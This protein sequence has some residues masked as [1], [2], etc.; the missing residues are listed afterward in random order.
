MYTSPKYR[1]HCK[2]RYNRLIA[3]YTGTVLLPIV[4]RYTVKSAADFRPTK[5]ARHV[6]GKPKLLEGVA[7][8]LLWYYKTSCFLHFL[9][10]EQ[11]IIANRRHC[12][13]LSAI[14]SHMLTCHATTPLTQP[15]RNSVCHNFQNN[16]RIPPIHMV[17][18]TLNTPYR[19]HAL[20]IKKHVVYRED[21][22][23]PQI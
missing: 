17:Y 13:F 10:W 19:L 14:A 12:A 20:Y 5:I 11:T 23:V 16:C 3:E 1:N 15:D 21:Q 7:H 2:Y 9:R 6:F 18:N 4:F 8:L 22:E